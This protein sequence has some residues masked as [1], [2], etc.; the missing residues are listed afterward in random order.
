MAVKGP[1]SAGDG[2]RAY[3]ESKVE[4]L[5]LRIRTK[6][7]DLKR[8]EAQRNELN[9]RGAQESRARRAGA[10]DRAPGPLQCRWRAAAAVR[11][12][13]LHRRAPAL[14]PCLPQ[15][16]CYA[17]SCSCCRSRAATWGR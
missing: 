5:E 1:V 3:Y 11:H 7:L 9:S 13:P 2:L 10:A 15:S 16:A 14:S 12:H 8:L 6:Q 4:E 17:R